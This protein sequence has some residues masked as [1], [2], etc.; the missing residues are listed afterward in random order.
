MRLGGRLVRTPALA[1]GRRL[2]GLVAVGRCTSR[3]L[4]RV[5]H[6]LG[7]IFSSVR[8]PLDDRC[9]RDGAGRRVGRAVAPDD[10]GDVAGLTA[11]LPTSSGFS[12]FTVAALLPEPSPVSELSDGGS[13]SAVATA[14]P[15]PVMMAV[16]TPR[17]TAS[18]PTRPI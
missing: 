18:P 6:P 5:G 15:C 8:Q 4:H 7:G 16:P 14:M 10:V 2:R 1:R 11:I 9:G 3:V 13:P 17:A 12:S